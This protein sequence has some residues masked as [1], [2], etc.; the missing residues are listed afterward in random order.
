MED[1]WFWANQFGAIFDGHGG[2]GVSR[3][4]RQHLYDYAQSSLTT[5]KG[6]DKKRKINDDSKANESSSTET[7]P[8]ETPVF[9]VQDYEDALSHEIRQVDREVKP[10]EGW[11]ITGSTA[12]AAWM[13]VGCSIATTKTTTTNITL[14]TAYVGDSRAVL[15]RNGGKTIVSLTRYHKPN[16]PRERDRI[17]AAGGQVTWK[18]MGWSNEP[19]PPLY[20]DT[21]RSDDH[22]VDAD[23]DVLYENTNKR[24]SKTGIYYVTGG[25]NPR[26]GNESGRWRLA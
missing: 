8:M 6:K 2:D 18:P 10:I 19:F 11:K 5:Q 25:K 22:D 12:I 23:D 3:Y 21:E 9:S 1:D 14:V 16:V 20:S 13:H 26:F 24:K 7:Q 17:L 4:L 15:S